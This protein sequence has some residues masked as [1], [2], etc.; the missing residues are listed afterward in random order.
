MTRLTPMRTSAPSKKLERKPLMTA[1][2][3]ASCYLEGVAHYRTRMV[4]VESALVTA[5]PS[6]CV[7]QLP[8]VQGWK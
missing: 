8:A 6:H 5:K 3:V 1:G 4:P 7:G 2:M